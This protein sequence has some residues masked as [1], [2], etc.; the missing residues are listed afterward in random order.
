MKSRREFLRLVAVGSAAALTTRAGHAAAAAKRAANAA[1]A[2]A[3][4]R[5]A[6]RSAA[7]VSEIEK[8]KKSTAEA[9]K[10]IRK[11][12]LPAGSPMAFSFRPLR[13]KR[14]GGAR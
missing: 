6:P 12:Q 5:A 2:P 13:A 8:Q 10:T 14:Q 3:G 1:V 11:Y 4:G 7:V 9:L